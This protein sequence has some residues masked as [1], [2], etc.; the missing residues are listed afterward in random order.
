MSSEVVQEPVE[1]D[2]VETHTEGQVTRT[3]VDGIDYSR[4][5]GAD[6]A[7]IREQFD[8]EFEWLPDF[9]VKEPRGHDNLVGSV[10][11]DVENAD[12]DL[13]M[14]FFDNAGYLD[15]CG[16]GLIG[17]TTALVETGRI[18]PREHLRVATP[19]GIVALRVSLD[20]GGGVE[21]VAIQDLEGFVYGHTEVTV[22]TSDDEVVDG[23]SRTVPVDVAYGAGNW[24]AYVD[25]DDLAIDLDADA[26]DSTRI[27]G[28]GVEIRRILN[29]TYEIV[30]PLTDERQSITITM[31]CDESHGVDRNAIVYGAGSIGRSPCGTGTAGKLALLL[32]RGEI[33]V[34]EEYPHESVIGTRFVGRILAT[35][36][37]E[38]VTVTTAEVG[39]SA[40]I[41]STGTLIRQ[42]DDGL[43]GYSL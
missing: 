5:R 43:T 9:L 39:G 41:I 23:A 19:G 20:A 24:Y 12:T 11:L 13:G 1:I 31:F 7:T 22:D 38:G 15:N 25:A 42:P 8:R 30:D 2:I 34:D 21:H 16:D 28:Y 6:I 27:V 36:E 3:V 18:E 35:D 4:L 40:H 10:P 17:T 37:R 32:S 33:A 26:G 29:E 14:I